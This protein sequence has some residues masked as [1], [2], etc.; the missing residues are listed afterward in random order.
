[1]E[2]LDKFKVNKSKTSRF[3]A[4]SLALVLIVLIGVLTFYVVSMQNE[5]QRVLNE[6]GTIYMKGMSEKISTHFET[7]V[8]LRM[9]PL[10][11]IIANNPPESFTNGKDQREKLLYEGGI[12]GY[13]YLAFLDSKG[14][15]HM[16]Y[17]NAVELE[18]PEPFMQSILSGKEKVA[19]GHSINDDKIVMMG[20]PATYRMDNSEQS[21]ALVAGIPASYINEILSLDTTEDMTYSHIIRRNGTFIIRNIDTDD[22]DYFETLRRT[23]TDTGDGS[24]DNIIR[25]LTSAMESRADYSSVTFVNNERRHIYCKPLAHSEWYLITIMPYGILNTTISELDHMRV[26]LFVLCIT[27]IVAVLCGVFVMYFAMTRK[28]IKLLDE[29]REAAK[30]ESKAKSEF[31]SNM[32]HDIRTPMNAIVGMTAIAQTHL[33]D[34]QQLENCLGK[35]SLSSKHLLGLINDILDMS[36]I[37]SGKMTLSISEISL[38]EIMDSVVS[39]VQPQVRAKH[40]HFDVFIDNIE[41]EHVFCD[42][43]RLNQVL[44]NLLSNAIKFTPEEGKIEIHLSEDESERGSDYTHVHISVEDNGIGMTEEFQRSVF[45]AFTREDSKRVNKTEGTGLGMA[46]TKFIVDAMNGTIE[47]KSELGKG[48]RFDVAVD[49]EKAE[50]PIEEMILPQ[51]HMLVVDDDE[52]I[53]TSAIESLKRIGIDAE[54]TLDGESAVKMIVKAANSPRPYQIILLDWKLPGIDGLE[55]AR[56]IRKALG[57]DIPILLISAYDWSEIESDALSAGI[58][59]FISKP[60]FQST[61]YYGL[62]RFV[63]PNDE[64]QKNS[65]NTD[66]VLNNSNDPIDSN[67]NPAPSPSAETASSDSEFSGKSKYDFNGTHILVAEDNDLNWE[68]A[69]EL[70]SDFGLEIDRAENGKL[71]V[72]MLEASEPGYYKAIL[73]DIRM[74]IMSG[75]EASESIRASEHADHNIPII[76]MTADAFSDDVKRCLDAGMNAHTSKPID[77]DNVVKLLRKYIN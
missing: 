5:S 36:K 53:C 51:W 60:L 76:A 33:N 28:Q 18:D 29:A 61:L 59:G 9:D 27:I 35:I 2:S 21:V 11:T 50:A 1:M 10:N 7:T 38:R 68:I 49:L 39:I 55:T 75:Y 48:T 63:S 54:C 14:E 64:I 73:M 71:C 13:D 19:V 77:V 44:L 46:I 43:L 23:V 52:M 69:N 16:I 74:P 56:E 66:S 42:S 4:A 41:Y 47:L 62:K 67:S 25:D 12:R 34:P 37:E 8:S 57:S 72:E 24:A 26:M 6:V 45:E 22:K 17:G 70:L 15:F 32:S 3:L 20:V 65:D 30:R 31:L 40:Q 58:T